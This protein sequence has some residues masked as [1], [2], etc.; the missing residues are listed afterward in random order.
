MD[1][2]ATSRFS[3]PSKGI[4]DTTKWRNVC[5]HQNFDNHSTK[6]TQR[7]TKVFA[8]FFKRIVFCFELICCSVSESGNFT[9]NFFFLFSCFFVRWLYT[10]KREKGRHY[11]RIVFEN[12]SKMHTKTRIW[13]GNWEKANIVLSSPEHCKTGDLSLERFLCTL[14]LFFE[15]YKLDS[16]KWIENLP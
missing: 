4:G 13:S 7:E 8:F 1:Q 15:I 9:S 6:L 16:F 10:D 5:Y 12:D 2:S 14:H 11:L 3:I